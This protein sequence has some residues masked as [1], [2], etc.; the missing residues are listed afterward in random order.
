MGK[1]KAGEL[2]AEIILQSHFGFARI[3]LDGG[4]RCKAQIHMGFQVWIERTSSILG[5]CGGV[6]GRL[7]SWGAGKEAGRKAKPES[8]SDEPGPDKKAEPVK[9]TLPQT[10]SQGNHRECVI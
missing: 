4:S 9:L 8:P 3:F 6:D 10:R 7:T 5:H 1:G 2:G